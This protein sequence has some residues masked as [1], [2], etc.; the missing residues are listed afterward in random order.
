MDR[1]DFLQATT[2]AAAATTYGSASSLAMVTGGPQMGLNDLV[3]LA[4]TAPVTPTDFDKLHRLLD[5]VS[6]LSTIRDQLGNIIS[7]PT[8]DLAGLPDILK[9][10]DVGA[11]DFLKDLTKAQLQYSPMEVEYLANTLNDHINNCLTLREKAQQLEVLASAARL[12]LRLEQKT[13]DF[14]T[15]MADHEKVNGSHIAGT[16]YDPIMTA[17]KIASSPGGDGYYSHSRELADILLNARRESLGARLALLNLSGS[18]NNHTQRFAFLKDSFNRELGEAFLR[19]R[20]V[21]VGCKEIYKLNFEAM[22]A[23][24]DVGYLNKLADWANIVFVALERAVMSKTSTVVAVALRKGSDPAAPPGLLP[25]ADYIAGRNN[26]AF[27]VKISTEFFSTI[28][29]NLKN[30][31]LRGLEVYAWTDAQL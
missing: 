15:A 21:A 7:A 24:T 29:L 16:M 13:I 26:G 11:A 23:P 10:I 20:S 30:P 5:D 2:F 22:P 27:N 6:P 18:G 31:R 8:P 19:A 14:L 9:P 12:E 4:A 28:T 17:S 3:Q 25:E 1:R